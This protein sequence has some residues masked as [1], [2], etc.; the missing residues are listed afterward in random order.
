MIVEH[1]RVATVDMSGLQREAEAARERLARLN[2]EAKALFE[3][4]AAF[5]G[6][7]CPGLAA[8]PYRVDRYGARG[9]G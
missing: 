7:F 3:Q 9:E 6:S 8:R 5:V 4:L 2:V 1:R